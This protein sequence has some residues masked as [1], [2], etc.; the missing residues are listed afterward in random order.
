MDRDRFIVLKKR[1]YGEA[2][3]IIFGINA[4][5]SKVSYL[6]PSALRSRKR[7][8]GGVFEPS[9]Y[10]EVVLQKKGSSSNLVRL[11]EAQIIKDFAGLRRDYEVLQVAL[12]LL[13]LVDKVGQ[14]G[15][16]HGQDLFNLLGNAL[17]TLSEI[18]V[19]SLPFFRLHFL[20]K[21]LSQQGVLPFEEWMQPFLSCPLRSHQLL[22]K[23]PL[24]ND[25]VTFLEAL[26]NVENL[27]NEYQGEYRGEH[28][29][30]R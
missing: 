18:N 17:Q 19:A 7:F 29:S 22:E 20:L 1:V 9:H 3:L 16:I 2:D 8:G 24:A 6:A 5:G 30:S 21:F 28:Q 12:S 15:D 11:Q 10:I 14:E 25:E 26:R 13:S 4:Q 27:V 23:S